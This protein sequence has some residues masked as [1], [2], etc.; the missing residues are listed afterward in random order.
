MQN[1]LI[2]LTYASTATFKTDI[3]G[4][5]ESEVARILLQSRRNNSRIAV[6]GVLHY[7]D[8]YFFQCLEGDESAVKST[9]QR[10]S[11]D[12]RHRDVQILLNV[13]IQRR[14]FE[15]WSMKYST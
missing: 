2:R 6:G 10:I 1:Q 15:D 3:K 8:G 5:I 14:L 12:Q 11:Q 4:G 9:L 13:Q 7:G